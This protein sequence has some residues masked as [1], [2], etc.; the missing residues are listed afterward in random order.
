MN[1]IRNKVPQL[2]I[3][4]SDVAAVNDLTN[5]C[6]ILFNNAREICKDQI[7]SD[8]S[9]STGKTSD[10][11]KES[12]VEEKK[13]K[14]LT[15]PLVLPH[16]G[17]LRR[18]WN[19]AFALIVND[20]VAPL[21]DEY[22]LFKKAIDDMDQLFD[23]AKGEG[24]STSRILDDFLQWDCHHPTYCKELDR[25]NEKVLFEILDTHPYIKQ[26]APELK[27]LYNIAD[28]EFKNTWWENRKTLS[29]LGTQAYIVTQDAKGFAEFGTNLYQELNIPWWKEEITAGRRTRIE[30]I[31]C[32]VCKVKDEKRMKQLFSEISAFEDANKFTKILQTIKS[33]FPNTHQ[34]LNQIPIQV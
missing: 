20:V 4:E 12:T 17:D 25:R 31:N 8:S 27:N 23:K 1:F 14:T 22:P 3:G 19:E 2:G 9:S 13:D 28:D 5:N 10:T 18:E 6:D 33:L 26:L 29:I 24:P 7:K 32:L 16:L 30:L 21:A 11:K 15:E 34:V